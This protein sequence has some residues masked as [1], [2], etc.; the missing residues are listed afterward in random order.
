MASVAYVCRA[1]GGAGGALT[2]WR[3]AVAQVK[4]HS[5]QHLR[6]VFCVFVL[7]A[8]SIVALSRALAKFAPRV[9]AKL[10]SEGIALVDFLVRWL[11]PFFTRVRAILAVLGTS[12]KI[13]A[14]VLCRRLFASR[15]TYLLWG[16]SD[17]FVDILSFTFCWLVLVLTPTLLCTLSATRA[18]R[19]SL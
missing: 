15:C 19:S 18:R 2:S 6:P 3:D 12:A 8:L 10:N 16:G 5:R 7:H 14:A 11:L 9:H 13:A 4:A 1:G 17:A